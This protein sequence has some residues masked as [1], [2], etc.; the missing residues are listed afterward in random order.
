MKMKMMV[1]NMVRMKSLANL[2]LVI[3][4]SSP[5]IASFKFRDVADH[6]SD[7]CQGRLFDRV[8]DFAKRE[9]SLLRLCCCF[10]FSTFVVVVVVSFCRVC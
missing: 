10:G 2:K 9:M 8:V 4:F 3:S 6:N 7:L 5:R 1:M